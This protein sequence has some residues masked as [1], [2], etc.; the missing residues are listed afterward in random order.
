MTRFGTAGIRGSVHTEV[1]PSLA[2]GVGR[3]TA[4][5]ARETTDT[6]TVVVGRDGRTTGSALADAL[7]AG[8][9]SGGAD[10]IRLGQVPTP[11]LAFASQGR[12]GVMV[13]ASHNPPTERSTTANWR[14]PSRD[15]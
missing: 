13:T 7:A 5:Q 4:T 2:L 14:R 11:A 6:P 8:L 12:R 3:A 15:C 10:V 9:Q 1:T